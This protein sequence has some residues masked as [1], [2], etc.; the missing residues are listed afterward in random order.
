MGGELVLPGSASSAPTFIVQALK[1]P[2][3]ANLDR[4]QII[5]G[6]VD[7]AGESHEQ[8]Y[9]VAWSGNRSQTAGGGLPAVGNTVDTASAR[10]ANTI[11]SPQLLALWRDPAFDAQQAAFYYSRVL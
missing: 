11:V 1:D 10:Y 9:N 2:T 3:G 7:V 8:V 5:K 6:W 4:I